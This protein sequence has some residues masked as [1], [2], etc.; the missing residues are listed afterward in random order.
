MADGYV[1]AS[2][3]ALN[4]PMAIWSP[5]Y[6]NGTGALFVW[7]GYDP[8][9]RCVKRWIGSATG[10]AVASNPATYYYYDGWNLIQEGMELELQAR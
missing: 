5:V 7:F 3:N 1:T 2:F 4:Q 6:P 9:G 8:L 10:N